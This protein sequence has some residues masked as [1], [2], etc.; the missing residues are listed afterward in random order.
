MGCNA[1]SRIAHLIKVSHGGSCKRDF[2]GGCQSCPFIAAQSAGGTFQSFKK[3]C[4]SAHFLSHTAECSDHCKFRLCSC[5]LCEAWHFQLFHPLRS[6]STSFPSGF[7]KSS[8]LSSFSPQRR[9]LLGASWLQEW[10][11]TLGDQLFHPWC[12]P[13]PFSCPHSCH[14]NCMK[15]FV[16]AQQVQFHQDPFWP[17]VSNHEAAMPKIA[18]SCCISWS[19]A[20]QAVLHFAFKSPKKG[21]HGAIAFLSTS[22]L[23]SNEGQNIHLK[24]QHNPCSQSNAEQP[25][26]PVA[27]IALK[28]HNQSPAHWQW[29]SHGNVAKQKVSARSGAQEHFWECMACAPLHNRWLPK[30]GVKNYGLKEETSAIDLTHMLFDMHVFL[31]GSMAR[32]SREVDLI[33]EC[34]FAD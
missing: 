15:L 8:C 4:T 28:T 20:L 2:F 6:L 14:C 13:Q 23:N 32:T 1:K 16:G 30:K 29:A 27:L 24:L 21:S 3:W 33:F 18:K 17:L 10:E 25:T 34:N 31:H 11:W 5:N 19:E 9:A 12:P 7:A 22:L 26:C